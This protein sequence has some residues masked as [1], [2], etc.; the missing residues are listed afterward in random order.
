MS[1]V[2]KKWAFTMCMATAHL[3]H[4]DAAIAAGDFSS[5]IPC[6]AIFSIN[7]EFPGARRVASGGVSFT[8]P[9]GMQQSD[10]IEFDSWSRVWQGGGLTISH[11]RGFVGENA[12]K[13]KECVLWSGHEEVRASIEARDDGLILLFHSPEARDTLHAITVL[14]TGDASITAAAMANI[15]GTFA[16]VDAWDGLQVLAIDVERGRFNYR[17]EVGMVRWARF[18]D[19][20][21]RADGKVV[22]IEANRVV[23]IELIHD[24]AGGYDEVER[25]LSPGESH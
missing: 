6:A 23:V 24:G 5:P 18:G 3:L 19:I 10:H 16:F 11:E 7:G 13:A 21:T 25:V 4:A 1:N 22:G 17:N 12:T 20:V 8:I 15:F 2:P 9:A 14:G